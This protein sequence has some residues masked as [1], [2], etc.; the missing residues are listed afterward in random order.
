LGEK[1]F[2]FGKCRRTRSGNTSPKILAR[3][4][5]RRFKKRLSKGGTEVRE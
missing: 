5:Q 4:T 2:R 3:A 1:K